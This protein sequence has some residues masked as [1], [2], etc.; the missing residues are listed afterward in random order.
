MNVMKNIIL[1]ILFIS[2]TSHAAQ[3][4]SGEF[5]GIIEYTE[6]ICSITINVEDDIASSNGKDY[7]LREA[8]RSTMDNCPGEHTRYVGFQ[9]NGKKDT[10]LEICVSSNNEFLLFKYE[11]QTSFGPKGYT[12]LIAQE[13]N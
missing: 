3:Y 6:E 9:I 5:V 2:S 10:E 7:E 13:Q 12:C 1:V 4:K 8:I 11:E